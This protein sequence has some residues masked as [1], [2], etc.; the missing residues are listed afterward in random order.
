[1]AKGYTKYNF[2]IA[3][4]KSASMEDC[5]KRAVAE[6]FITPEQVEKVRAAK[7]AEASTEAL[8]NLVAP[9]AVN[10]ADEEVEEPTPP[11]DREVNIHDVVSDIEGMKYAIT[12]TGDL[13]NITLNIEGRKTYHGG[14]EF[15]VKAL[16]DA[17]IKRKI[18]NEGVV[19]NLKTLMQIVKSTKETVE[20][21]WKV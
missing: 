3:W 13:R 4:L 9:A 18:A 11:P 5:I 15:V 20:A 8:K 1:L 6:G 2:P 14:M 10:D 21:T 12:T 17:L 19:S 7:A 16:I